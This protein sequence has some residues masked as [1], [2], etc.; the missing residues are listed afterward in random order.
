ME[1]RACRLAG[2]TALAVHADG[3]RAPR[4]GP[5][6]AALESIKPDAILQ[7]I[8][9]LASD[10]FEGRGPG[11]PGE[12]KTIA[13]LTGQF[14]AMGLKPGNP[15]GT[16]V[17]NVPLVGFQATRVAGSFQAGG[18]TI[19]L[20]FPRNFVAVSGRAGEQPKVDDS[21]VVFVGYGVVAPGVRLG[22]LQGPR[23][24][25]QDADHA[26][27]RPAGPR[28]PATRRSSTRPSSRAGR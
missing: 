3:C 7:H 10:E 13:Y 23:R 9:V 24:P 4:E 11:T 26:G 12:E 6:E 14:R 28:S 20:E 19:A 18:Q 8:K 1:P 25:R 22:R 27:Q 16:F 5:L 21:E 2:L 17:Q 15:D